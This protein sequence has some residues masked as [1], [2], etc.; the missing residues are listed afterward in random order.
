MDPNANLSETRRIV[1]TI[2]EIQDACPDD[3]DYTDR[4]LQQLARHANRLA[5]LSEAL[6]GWLSSGGFFPSRWGVRA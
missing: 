2:N 1:R 6:D 5:E 3:G 4:Q